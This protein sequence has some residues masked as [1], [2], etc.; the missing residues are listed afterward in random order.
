[1]VLKSLKEGDIKV[2]E[3]HFRRNFIH[4]R[5]VASAILFAIKNFQRIKNNTYNSK[6]L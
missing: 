4:V 1:M 2:F 3:P 6:K 5:D